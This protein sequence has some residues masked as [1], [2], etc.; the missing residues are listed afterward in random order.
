MSFK[1]GKSILGA[2]T[3]LLLIS[4]NVYATLTDGL[5]AHYKF[6]GD[7]SDS[8]GNGNNG[9][10]YG[11]QLT[12][13]RFGVANHAYLF[14]GQD[15]YIEAAHS[16]SLDLTGPITLSAW[17]KSDGTYWQSEII[18]KM[19]SYSPAIG[20]QLYTQDD[21]ARVSLTYAIGNSHAGGGVAS[22][23]LVVDGQWHLLTSTYDGSEIRMYV[24]G[25]LETWIAYSDGYES[26][27]EPLKIG[28]YYYPYNDGR[29]GSH[30]WALNGAIDDVRIYNRALSPEE[31]AQLVPEPATLLLFG[32]G[33]L[34]LRR[35]HR[36]K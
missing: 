2:T 11:A 19:P 8:S 35:K 4:C 10:V 33:G 7:A 20:Y 6:N 36:A 3:I 27:T 14:D 31:V 25:E 17:I 9:V 23:T 18:S 22:N 16:S 30:N 34:A 26:N 12:E 32:L 29:G 13:D 28:H 21:E 24:D 5:A 15:D 1:F